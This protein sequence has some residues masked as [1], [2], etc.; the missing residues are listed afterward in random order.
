MIALIP[1]SAAMIATVTKPSYRSALTAHTD[2]SQLF[3]QSLSRRPT[4]LDHPNEKS[5]PIEEECLLDQDEESSLCD[6]E[7][8]YESSQTVTEWCQTWSER[9]FAMSNRCSSPLAPAVSQRTRIPFMVASAPV[10]TH[11]EVGERVRT[12][13]SSMIPHRDARRRLAQKLKKAAAERHSWL[14]ICIG[15]EC[16]LGDAQLQEQERELRQELEKHRHALEA[17]ED[18]QR[19]CLRRQEW[20]DVGA[21][22][23]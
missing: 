19:E 23:A 14:S 6:T 16:E 9:T 21:F 7:S 2:N 3:R 13:R 18:E 22:L 10:M 17:L 5:L 20:E 1:A 11:D 8:T 12:I 4:T 15:E